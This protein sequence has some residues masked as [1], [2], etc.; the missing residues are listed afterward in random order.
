LGISI[1]QDQLETFIT[2]AT[3]LMGVIDEVDM[4]TLIDDLKSLG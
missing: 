3:E 2:S 1:P 4:S